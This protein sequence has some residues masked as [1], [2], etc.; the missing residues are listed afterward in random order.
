MSPAE[1]ARTVDPA[2]GKPLLLRHDADGVATVTLN[3]PARYNPLSEAMLDAL[4]AALDAIA[5]DDSVRVVVLASQG[6][7]FS[8]GHDLKEMRG[9]PEQSYYEWLFRK[10]SAVMLTLQQ[11]PVPVIARVQGLATAAGC[12]LVAAA[13]L[14]VA[15]RTAQFATSGIRVGLFCMTPGVAVSR[16]ISRKRSAEML[17]SGEFID[18]ATALDWGLVNR[19]VDETDLDATVAELASHILD[20]SRAAIAAGKRMFYRQLQMG[21]EGAYD[22]AAAEMAA[23]MM[24]ADAQE[25]IDAFLARRPPVW[26]HR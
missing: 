25:G 7:A 14:A 15:A 26:R 4:Q 24:F 11:L 16:A 17:M 10:C 3:R 6:K 20:K 8:A 23:N 13:D 1:P 22:Y 19:V 21:V 12:Q 18:A 9:R 5:A 2:A